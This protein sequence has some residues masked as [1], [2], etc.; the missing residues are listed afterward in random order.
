[1]KRSRTTLSQPH[2]HSRSEA[3]RRQSFSSRFLR[4]LYL[5]LAT[6]VMLAIVS[7]PVFAEVKLRVEARPVTDPINVFVTVTNGNGA[8][9]GGL[10]SADFTV[11]V[12]GVQVVSPTFSLSPIQDSEQR[13]SIVFAMDYS[14]S[15]TEAQ[16]AM[17]QS[18]LTFLQAM[19]VG[20]YAAIIKFNETNAQRVAVLQPFT[21]I[22]NGNGSSALA[23]AV[24]TPYA[25][26][27]S[28]VIDALMAAVQLFVPP[29]QL[30][31]GPKVIILVSD[32]GD[33]TSEFTGS[34]VVDAA[35]KQS[36]SVF[37]VGVGPL[38]ELVSKRDITGRKLLQELTFQTGG[39][40]YEAPDDQAIEDA[41]GTIATL[42]QNEYL[43][44]FASSISDCNVHVVDVRV[45][46]FDP[47]TSTFTRCNLPNTSTPPPEGDV[48]GTPLPPP[49]NNDGSQTSDGGGGGAFGPLGLIAG[50]S[51]L[52]LRRRLWVD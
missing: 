48:G 32:G 25:G 29:A 43:L 51:L 46:D 30:P 1:M 13:V 5:A 9:V 19:E 45:T 49:S 15:T 40:Y 52:A 8:P 18:V 37:S 42:L 14:T 6:F 23:G 10:T 34:A 26:S 11:L 47:A 44:T 22:D 39:Q 28:P 38:D 4:P 21:M 16:P 31:A 17:E 20:D 35:L 3:D 33:N 2:E 7:A 36:I 24:T 12:D 41:Y 50:L 27:G